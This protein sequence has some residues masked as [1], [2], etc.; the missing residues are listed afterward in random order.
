[1]HLI[2]MFWPPP[3][4]LASE[5]VACVLHIYIRIHTCINM[6]IKK[7]IYP[8]SAYVYCIYA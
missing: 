1:M 2:Y 3:I 7:Y 8:E 5:L 6:P 4:S